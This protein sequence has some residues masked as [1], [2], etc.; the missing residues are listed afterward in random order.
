MEHVELHLA[1]DQV[2]LR[3]I[4]GEDAVFVHQG[5]RQADAV[6]VAQQRHKQATA[7]RQVLQPAVEFAARLAQL[8]Q[9][10]RVDTRNLGML[11]HLIEE[12]QDSGRFTAKQFRIHRID[13][14]AT[15]LELV[16]EAA[17]IHGGVAE[18][19]FVKQLQQHLVE[20]RDPPHSLVEAL[21]HL[22][23]A[24]CCL[25]PRTPASGP[26]CAGDR[27]VGGYLPC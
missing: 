2:P 11:G 7:V 18:D 15:E 21:H 25:P 16:G 24:E 5:E 19:R 26:R 10:G 9:G 4:G 20:L 12:A 22:L 3:Q 6:G 1:D 8:A 23:D 13:E 17:H 14:A 27:T